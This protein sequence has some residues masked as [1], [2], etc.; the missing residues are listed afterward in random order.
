MFAS[1]ALIVVLAIQKEIGLVGY[2]IPVKAPSPASF[3]I[4]SK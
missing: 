1:E 3:A 2:C 4:L